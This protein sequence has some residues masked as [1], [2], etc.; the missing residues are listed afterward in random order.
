VL[1]EHDIANDNTGLFHKTGGR[2]DGFE[3][4]KW[5][6]HAS[7]VEESVRDLQGAVD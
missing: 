2:N 5:A 3:A 6:D 1:A 7:I 4:L